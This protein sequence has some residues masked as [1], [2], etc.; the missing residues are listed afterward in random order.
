MWSVLLDTDA[1]DVAID[2]IVCTA[3]IVTEHHNNNTVCSLS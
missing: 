1:L 3:D 2:A